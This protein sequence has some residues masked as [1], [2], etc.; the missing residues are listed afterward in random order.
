MFATSLFSLPFCWLRIYSFWSCPL[1]MHMFTVFNALYFQ[2]SLLSCLLRGTRKGVHSLLEEIL[3]I[4][5]ETLR[6]AQ[7]AYP[8]NPVR[9]QTFICSGKLSDWCH[10]I[11]HDWPVGWPK[12]IWMRFCLWCLSSLLPGLTESKIQNS[13]YVSCPAELHSVPYFGEF[14]QTHIQV[15]VP[16]Q[17]PLAAAFWNWNRMALCTVSWNN[18]SALTWD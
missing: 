16:S 6:D 11:W 1:S 4:T 14:L 12:E 7:L 15:Y 18:S 3:A 13:W 5:R 8:R 17:K 10:V 9:H 2:Q